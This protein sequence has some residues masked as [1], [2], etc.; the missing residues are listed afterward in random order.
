MNV[1]PGPAEPVPYR[2]HLTHQE[3]LEPSA[4]DRV[5]GSGRRTGSTS[6]T[7]L[8]SCHTITVQ[9]CVMLEGLVYVKVATSN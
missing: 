2:G 6:L 1:T 7:N 8:P 4:S 3:F 5:L 9:S